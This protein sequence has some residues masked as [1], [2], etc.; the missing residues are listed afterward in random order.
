MGAVLA[1]IDPYTAPSRPAASRPPTRCRRLAASATARY[2]AD[3]FAFLQ[4]AGCHDKRQ[5]L[6]AVLA[7]VAPGFSRL[8]LL[9]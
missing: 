1:S 9:V 3:P 4:D 2:E 8:L 7:A 6:C 5:L